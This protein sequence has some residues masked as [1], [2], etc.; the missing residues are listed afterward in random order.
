[1]VFATRL[2]SISRR[3]RGG[4]GGDFYPIPRFR[5]FKSRENLMSWHGPLHQRSRDLQ[6]E[7]PMLRII[8]AGL[9]EQ[10]LVHGY[11]SEICQSRFFGIFVGR[12]RSFNILRSHLTASDPLLPKSVLLKPVSLS[13]LEDSHFTRRESLSINS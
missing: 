12:W 3:G 11:W 7:M 5:D 6:R 9:Y 4:R 13:S 8:T 1:M 10:L 2:V